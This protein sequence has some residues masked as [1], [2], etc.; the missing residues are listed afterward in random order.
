MLILSRRE[1]EK[2]LFPKLGITI[3]VT[4]VQGRTVR[5]GIDA[6]DEIRIIRAELEDSADLNVKPRINSGD[7]RNRSWNA[8]LDVQKCL[9]A[10]NLAIHLA[11][12]Q[13]RQQL[14][15]RAEEAL[16]HALECLENLETAAT[17]T[18]S[19][20]PTSPSVH[21]AKPGYRCSKPRVAIFVDD[22]QHVGGEL[23]HRLERLGYTTLQLDSGRSLIDFLQ[24]RDQPNLVLTRQPPNMEEPLFVEPLFG[25]G[26]LL[27]A[28]QERDDSLGDWQSSIA[29]D[30]SQAPRQT[31][32][33]GLRMFGVG[34]LQKSSQTYS[35]GEHRITGWFAESSD[36][37]AMA[38]CFV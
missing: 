17:Q 32:Q 26:C 8:P 6:P 33:S 15:D 16:D 25:D 4:R 38:N 2:V 28:V 37:D 13:L 1:A 7:R 22:N 30:G 36:A 34:S 19:W 11:Q 5:L 18:T 10:A 21:E 12:N 27:D 31:A 35:L 20:E 9:D 23:K 14:N 24:F 3:E 29:L